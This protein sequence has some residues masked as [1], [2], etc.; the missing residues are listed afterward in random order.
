MRPCGAGGRGRVV[1]LGEF[2]LVAV[3]RRI[4]GSG[5]VVLGQQGGRLCRQVEWG[6]ASRAKSEVCGEGT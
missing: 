1:G 6:R 5:R 2:Y 4:R 3:R